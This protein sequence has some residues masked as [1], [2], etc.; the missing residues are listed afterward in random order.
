MT[1]AALGV[2]FGTGGGVLVDVRSSV[3]A[4]E[5]RAGSKVKS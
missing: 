3:G 1:A 2:G 4:R 5:G